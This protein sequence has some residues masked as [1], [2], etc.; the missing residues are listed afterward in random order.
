[1]TRMD[2]PP[3]ERAADR[4][5]EVNWIDT[6]KASLRYAHL[7]RG[8]G[9]PLILLHEMGGTLETWDETLPLL[10]ESHEVLAYDWRG[11]GQSEKITG[12]ITVA[13]H[14]ADLVALLDALQID[15]PV[16]IAGVA[17]GT[18]IACGFAAACPD[19]AAGLVLICPA[20]DVRAA[21]RDSRLASIAEFETGG[22][23][24]AVEASLAGGYPERFRNRAD[25]RFA[26]FRARWLANDPE[27]FGATYRM[28]LDMQIDPVLAQVRCPVRLVAGEYDPV[29]TPAYVQTVAA[30]IADASLVT[31]PGGH[32]MPHQIPEIVA[33]TIRAFAAA[34]AA[35]GGR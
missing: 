17:V 22:M 14:V 31:V 15:G 10:A 8:R 19:R 24:A 12:T 2:H 29:R 5:I 26:R 33:G 27:S 34:L 30:R 4:P 18:A 6:G 11:F 16:L 3:V 25:G 23:R 21:D 9:L 20:L 35:G 1:M 32:H 28:L 13:D 7:G